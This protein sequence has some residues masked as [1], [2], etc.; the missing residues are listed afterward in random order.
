MD[1]K[2]GTFIGIGAMAI[3]CLCYFYQQY[4]EE[5]LEYKAKKKSL[6]E[7]C[8][9]VILA[10]AVDYDA[11]QQSGHKELVFFPA[12]TDYKVT[13]ATYKSFVRSRK[14]QF[15]SPR[16]MES[17][18]ENQLGGTFEFRDPVGQRTVAA[19]INNCHIEEE[20]LQERRE[21]CIVFLDENRNK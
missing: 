19:E 12:V 3:A 8:R 1:N 9:A 18:R 15:I 7:R 5:R 21:K 16:T 13:E 11:I 2:E 10:G 20:T 4:K 17:M 6:E 14:S